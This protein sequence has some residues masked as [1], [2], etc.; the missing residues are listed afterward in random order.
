MP[1][2]FKVPLLITP[3]LVTSLTPLKVPSQSLLT[4]RRGR[5]FSAIFFFG[6]N[7]SW[8]FYG[9]SPA[10]FPSKITLSPT[11]APSGGLINST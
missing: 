4:L 11:F 8:K 7:I 3:L 5:N 2:S 6:F 9:M 10:G 1:Q